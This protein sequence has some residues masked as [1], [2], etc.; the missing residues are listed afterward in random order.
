MTDSLTFI[1]RN[2]S[3]SLEIYE[4]Q[5]KVDHVITRSE[6]NQLRKYEEDK[7]R[8]S[9]SVAVDELWQT[10]PLVVFSTSFFTSI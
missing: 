2:E 9:V 6:E 3:V 10:I 4:M 5:D 7:K 8:Y 1:V